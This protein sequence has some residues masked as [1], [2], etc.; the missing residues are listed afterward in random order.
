M[1]VSGDWGRPRRDCAAVGVRR[2]AAHAC[3]FVVVE[4]GD[5]GAWRERE[6]APCRLVGSAV[7]GGEFGVRTSGVG[8]SNSR[9]VQAFAAAPQNTEKALATA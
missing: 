4:P 2:A 8:N 7:C 3:E 9:P 6:A 5:G 1:E